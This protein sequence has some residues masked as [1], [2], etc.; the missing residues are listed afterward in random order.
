MRIW[1]PIVTARRLL[2]LRD[3]TIMYLR[4]YGLTPLS[5]GS[6]HSVWTSQVAV[7]DLASRKDMEL[8]SGLVLNDSLAACG[9]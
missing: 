6:A 8:T 7:Y 4:P 3:E 9:Q 1:T 5:P 2:W